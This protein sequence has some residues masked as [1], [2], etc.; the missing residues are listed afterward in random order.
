M[1]TP[2][3]YIKPIEDMYPYK[4][5]GNP[6]SYS[7][8]NEGWCDACG[9]FYDVIDQVQKDVH[10]DI[11]SRLEALERRSE[12]INKILDLMAAWIDKPR[13]NSYRMKSKQQIEQRIAKKRDEIH[14]INKEIGYEWAGVYWEQIDELAIEIAEL[15][16]VLDKR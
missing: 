16:W 6:D 13:V 2:E 9:Q 10:S 1:K 14:R 8:Y 12:Y 4:K 5:R 15:E 3:E 7:E 11:E